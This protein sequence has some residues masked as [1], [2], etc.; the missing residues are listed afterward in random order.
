MS[1]PEEALAAELALSGAN[2]WTKLQGTVTSQLSVEF[3]LDGSIRQLS[4][5][6]PDADPNGPAYAVGWRSCAATT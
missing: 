6:A 4:M 3:E 1:A 2:A 5:P